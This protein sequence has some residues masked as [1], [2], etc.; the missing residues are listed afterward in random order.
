VNANERARAREKARGIADRVRTEAPRINR[1]SDVTELL[2]V[3]A[4]AID[5]LADVI[6]AQDDSR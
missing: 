5:E 2:G 6:E 4:N 3:I 1:F